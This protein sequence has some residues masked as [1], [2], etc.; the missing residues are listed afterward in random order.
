LKALKPLSLRRDISSKRPVLPACRNVLSNLSN[1]TDD[2]ATVK[3][4]RGATIGGNEDFTPVESRSA[5][6]SFIA[7]A[8]VLYSRPVVDS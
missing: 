1:S 4:R 8:Y 5:D 2:E 7:S 6:H 3:Y